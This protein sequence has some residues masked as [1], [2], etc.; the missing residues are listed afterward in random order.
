MKIMAPHEAA[1]VVK[2][3]MGNDPH[4]LTFSASIMEGKYIPEGTFDDF[5]YECIDL[6]MVVHSYWVNET[7]IISG[8]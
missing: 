4:P 6:G 1:K 5:V 8:R 7:A 3:N 2:S